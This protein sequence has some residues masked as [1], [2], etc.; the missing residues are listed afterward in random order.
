[1]KYEDSIRITNGY[2]GY[3]NLCNSG[4]CDGVSRMGV[5]GINNVNNNQNQ[6]VIEGTS[7]SPVR[8]QQ[9]VHI[10]L[11]GSGNKYYADNC[12]YW[13]GATTSK[14]RDGL[15]GTWRIYKKYPDGRPI[16]YGEEVYIINR[17]TAKDWYLLTNSKHN[18]GCGGYSVRIFSGNPGINSNVPDLPAATWKFE[19]SRG[20][21]TTERYTRC[22]CKRPA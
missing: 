3:L 4:P 12:T 10:R 16:E 7:G 21:Q 15:S 1:M 19:R 11:L 22:I 9:D 13:G 17:Y 20:P 6:W 18:D 2:P 8:A 14:T 5:G